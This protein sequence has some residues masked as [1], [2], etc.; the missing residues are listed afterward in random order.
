ME[1]S[2]YSNADCDEVSGSVTPSQ[3]QELLKFELL[4]LKTDLPP[5]DDDDNSS[6]ASMNEGCESPLSSWDSEPETD[7]PSLINCDGMPE[8]SLQSIN[9]EENYLGMEEQNQFVGVENSDD[10]LLWEMDNR[11]YDDLVKKFLEKEEE[12]R[13]SNFRLELLEQENINLKVQAENSEGQLE[14]VS[15]E[16][17]LK[18]EELHKQRE[19]SE[20]E[21]S[22]LKIQI[23]KSEN[24]LNNVNKEL[25]RKEEELKIQKGVWEKGISYWEFQIEKSENWLENVS[26]ELKLKEEELHKQ[27]E[28]SEE[29]IFKLK[30]QIEKSENRLNNVNKE[31]KRKEEELKIQKELSNKDIWYLKTQLEKRE[32]QLN[33]VNEELKL[34]EEELEIQK[35]LSEE[36]I[37]KFKVQFVKSE[38]RY[39]TMNEELKLKKEELNKQKEL[40]EEEIFKLK[41]QIEKSEIQL[42]NVNEELKL[43]EEELNK[44][45]EL[46]D[47][48]IFKLKTQIEKSGEEL[49]LKREEPLKIIAD[50]TNLVDRLEVDHENL[51]KQVK[52]SK[53]EIAILRMELNSKSCETDLLHGQLKVTAQSALELLAEN[54]KLGDLVKMYE[55]NE[56]NHEQE[57]RKL[58][59][60]LLDWQAKFSFDI[61]SLSK[62]N[63]ELTSKLEDCN[64]RNKK[65]ENKLRQYEAEKLNQEELHGTQKIVLQDEIISLRQELEQRMDDAEATDKQLDMVMLELVEANVIIDNFKAEICSRDD[66]ISNMQKYIDDVK[67]SLK[68]LMMDYN[69]ALNELYNVNLRLGELEKEVTRQNGVISDM[70]E[71][72]KEAIRQLCL[73]LEDYK[74][75]LEHCK[76]GYNELLQTLYG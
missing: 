5:T 31:L 29:E 10:G 6:V 17:K 22:K 16:L 8:G 28:F 70:A 18:E 74:S 53:D 51:V 50:I 34:K 54:R 42:N 63:M 59:S 69:T 4:S 1:S 68:E 13:L 30:N 35:E 73:S 58:K 67:T 49:N 52:I 3:K 32:N 24:R 48:E 39:N 45:K 40:S 21:I 15:K 72:K 14:N 64:S 66:K 27:R 2:S 60:E 47:E 7:I 23:E 41:T 9:L 62:M 19:L 57:V 61:A 11:S 37:V 12:L 38:I 43:K 33:N 71:E 46:S 26:K 20:E 56:T 55:A 44:Q 65:L 75:K 25:K 36:K 76:S